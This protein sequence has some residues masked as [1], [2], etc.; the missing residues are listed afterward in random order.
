MRRVVPAFVVALLAALVLSVALPAGTAA[1]APRKRNVT[2]P[3]PPVA[4]PIWGVTLPDAPGTMAPVQDLTAR[5]GRRPDEVMWFVAW[6]LRSAFP[7]SEAA[8]VAAGGATPVITWEPWDPAAGTQQPAYALARI[9]AGDHDAYVT[10]WARAARAYGGPVVLRFAHEMN[11]TWYPWA[12]GVNGNTSADY[13]AAWRRV[14]RIFTKQR[15][16]NVQ[17]SWSPNVPFPGTAPLRGLYPGDDVVNRVALDGYNWGG[18]LE[19]TAWTSFADLFR[20]GAAEVKAITAKPLHVGEVG[21]PE[22]GGDKAAWVRDMLAW[23]ATDTEVAGLT[24]F[25]F[26]KESDWRIDSSAAT[27]DA[28][29]TGLATY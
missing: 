10:S 27:L 16:T 19:G 1:A 15:A 21:A 22:V 4:A 11:G 6:S 20:A 2:P 12:V 9:A 14:H 3:P 18:A 24:W 26:D 5:L 13:V 8:A 17:W 28:F 23:L 7:A 29:R 25:S